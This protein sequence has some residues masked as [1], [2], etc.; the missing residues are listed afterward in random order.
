[1]GEQW[2]IIP[3]SGAKLDRP[4]PARELYVGTMFRRQLAV[5]E[6]DAFESD[7]TVLV[8]S[9][10][11]GLITLT[12]VVDPD[13]LKMGQAGS[14]TV[15]DVAGQAFDF[16]I[17]Y[18]ADYGADVY[19]ILPAAYYRV[20]DRALRTLDVYLTD[21]YEAAAGVGWQRHVLRTAV[22]AG[23]LALF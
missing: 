12:A 11:Y 15:E 14:V 5:A 19:G 4:A 17:D 8:L 1:M 16:G 9:A 22:D 23:Q 2:V 6:S 3:C 10:A 13:D 20:A 7:R 18:G 21:V